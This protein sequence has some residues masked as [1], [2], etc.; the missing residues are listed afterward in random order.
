[1]VAAL[2]E[3]AGSAPTTPTLANALFAIQQYSSAAREYGESA[4]LIGDVSSA[5]PLPM[6]QV[7]ALERWT[8]SGF[9]M[10]ASG[11]P[12]AVGG[13]LGGWDRTVAQYSMGQEDQD[14]ALRTAPKEKTAFA[15]YFIGAHNVSS[16]NAEKA[17]RFLEKAM[18][19]VSQGDWLYLLAEA[20]RAA[21]D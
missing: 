20:E 18:E 17:S 21:L 6:L 15:Y 8:R 13:A 10:G 12:M 11:M 1:V 4:E 19:A 5:M 3:V 14:T 7:L 2:F 16:G 9:A